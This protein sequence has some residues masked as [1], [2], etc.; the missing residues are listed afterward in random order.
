MADANVNASVSTEDYL[1]FKQSLLDMDLDVFDYDKKGYKVRI[2]PFI[3]IHAGTV[4]V[5][6]NFFTGK[7]TT[8][9]DNGLR[10]NPLYSKTKLVVINSREVDFRPQKNLHTTEPVTTNGAK[11]SYTVPMID[12]K[13]R[14][15]LIDPVMFEE[16]ERVNASKGEQKVLYL[17]YDRVN[18]LVS[19]LVRRLSWDQLLV[20]T[21]RNAGKIGLD[22][23]DPSHDLRQFAN[24]N[25]IEVSEFRVQDIAIPEEIKKI[26]DADTDLKRAE[27]E[28][29][30]RLAAAET[31][32][33]E[34]KLS[35]IGSAFANKKN[36][37]A[38]L[39]AGMDSKDASTVM[40]MQSI[41]HL[42]NGVNP[43]IYFGNGGNDNTAQ[44]AQLMAS[45]QQLIQ[46][47]NGQQRTSNGNVNQNI[48][49]LSSRIMQLQSLIMNC[50]NKLPSNSVEY[51]KC[52]MSLNALNTPGNISYYNSLSDEEF[53]KIVDYYNDLV[54]SQ[55]NSNGRKRS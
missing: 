10:L 39:G 48:S 13:I 55:S 15:K 43:V 22:V 7:I 23:L 36:A 45:M 3:K 38:L 30:K 8:K 42:P 41:E 14:I 53:N 27:I 44:V 2:W 49:N 16:N 24:D 34:K 51:Q 40:G 46:Q 52:S 35:G 4:L 11:L 20:L 33:K 29:K 47:N 5:K 25:G 28:N 37:E 18:T 12:C 9:G 17:L 1:A 21:S 32:A 31:A 54:R 26:T 50:M 6:R 19:A